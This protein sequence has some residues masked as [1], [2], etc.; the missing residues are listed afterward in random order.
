[1]AARIGKAQAIVAT[2][3]KLAI[4]IYNALTFGIGYIEQGETEYLKKQEN[5]ERNKLAQLAKKYNYD[6]VPVKTVATQRP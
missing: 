6:I 2:C 4:L 3:R 1:M 5:W